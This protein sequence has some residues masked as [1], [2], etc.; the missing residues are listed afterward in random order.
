MDET[1]ITSLYP[2]LVEQ[3]SNA[4]VV[5]DENDRI[6]LFNGAAEQL[7]GRNRDEVIGASIS[8]LMPP[9][10]D[11]QHAFTQSEIDHLVGHNVELPIERP[12]NTRVWAEIS[13]S[14]VQADNKT[15]R[16]VTAR[17]ITLTK[18]HK[19]FRY[20]IL[21]AMAQTNSLP[22]IMTLLCQEIERIAPEISATIA[23]VDDGRLHSLVAPDFPSE[24]AHLIDGLEIGPKT[25]SQG[26]AAFRGESVLV[27]DIEHDPCW[28]VGRQETLALGYKACWSMPIKTRDSRMIGVLT[29]YYRVCRRPNKLHARLAEIAISLCV[30]A[31]E[32]AESFSRIHHLAF[33]DDLT[34]LPN[35]SLLQVQ[36]NQAIA[37]AT[38]HNER[39][40]VLFIDIDRFKQVNDSLGHPAGDSLL[41]TVA[42]RLREAIREVDIL[43][44]YSGDEF[45][46]V[47]TQCDNVHAS[48]LAG[49]LLVALSAPCRIGEVTLNP[50]ASIG[51]SL[52]PEN[53]RDMET[54]VHEADMAMYQA[55][56]KGRGCF[57]FFTGQLNQIAKDRLT[58][59]TA[60]RDAISANELEIY[61]QPQ[62][63]IETHQLHGVEALVRWNSN[64]LGK[65]PPAR[66]IPLAEESGLISTLS[67]WVLNE[68]CRQLSQWRL[69]G[70]AIPSISVNLSPTDFHNLNLKLPQYL[71]AILRSHGL[72]PNDLLVEITE[73]VLMDSNP[74]TMR[75]LNEI[76]ALGVRLSID[77]FGTGYSSLGYLRHL[78]VHELK[79]DQSFVRDLDDRATRALTNAVMH[80]GDS[81]ELTVIAEGVEHP[82]QRNLLKAQGYQIIQG[83]LF[84]PPLPPT[85]LE[86]WLDE[87]MSFTQWE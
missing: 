6:V 79:L 27:R 66:F 49:R 21:R 37:Q 70:L 77:D 23:K 50:A 51:I 4:I 22:E 8:K 57:S 78:P 39:L 68:A 33:F 46:I 60:L 12:N 44:R 26:I 64:Q 82:T 20:E 84:S 43:G 48:E 30:L 29:F 85:A 56:Q 1:S 67:Q 62:V 71:E 53:G 11:G 38:R 59:E 28:N 18:V 63:N 52:F 10:K 81:M 34:S 73:G 54:L 86:R 45:V 15:M 69:R 16:L 5:V 9:M 65:I 72:R 31:M 24:H 83:Y 87:N 76:H 32:R 47:L 13:V 7:W 58:L 42:S 80:I 25:S 3:A 41:R 61:Y 74:S 36:A 2:D 40:A 35:R 14:H 55:K 19:A 75:T 17:N